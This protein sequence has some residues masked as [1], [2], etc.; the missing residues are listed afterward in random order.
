LAYGQIPETQRSQGIAFITGGVGQGEGD[1]I[2]AEAKQWPVLL[3]LSQLENGRGIWIFGAQI[4]IM[5][6]RQKV[7]F[8]AQ[9]DGPYM[10]INLTPG[11]YQITASYQGAQQL[12]ALTVKADSSQKI[13]IFW[14]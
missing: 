8:D 7:I 5:N 6:Q 4:S 2:L 1:A 11:D 9:A 13:N 14:K 10:L 12:R 3:E